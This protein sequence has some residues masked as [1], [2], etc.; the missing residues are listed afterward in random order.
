MYLA[1]PMSTLEL[2]ALIMPGRLGGMLTTSAP[3]AGRLKPWV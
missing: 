2:R 1:L 3:R